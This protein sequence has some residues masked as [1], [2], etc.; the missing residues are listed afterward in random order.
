M[1][2]SFPPRVGEHNEEIYG[3]V[4]GYDRKRIRG[5]KEAGVI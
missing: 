5:L 2:L 1:R 3:G 4:L